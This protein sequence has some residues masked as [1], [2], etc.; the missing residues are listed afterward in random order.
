MPIHDQGYR[1]YLGTRTAIGRAWQVMA[2][3][4]ITSMVGTEAVEF[5]CEYTDF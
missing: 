5:T 1:R 3:A 4:G 2:R